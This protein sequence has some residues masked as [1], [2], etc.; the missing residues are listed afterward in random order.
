[1]ENLPLIA[2]TMGDPSGIGPEII[3]KGLTTPPDVC[4]TVVI[5]DAPWLQRIMGIRANASCKSHAELDESTEL[6]DG[7]PVELGN[8]Y[9]DFKQNLHHLSVFGGC[10]GTDQR[11]VEAICKST[12]KAHHHAQHYH[13]AGMI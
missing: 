2:I 9:R 6:D 10:C 11:H 1:M 8:Q 5:G 3:A 12:V 4:R 13:S 7:D